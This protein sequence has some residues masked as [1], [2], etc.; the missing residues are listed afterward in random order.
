MERL[1]GWLQNKFSIYL[2]ERVEFP[3][4][5]VSRRNSGEVILVRGEES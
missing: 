4:N 5:E 2:W 3:T 1:K